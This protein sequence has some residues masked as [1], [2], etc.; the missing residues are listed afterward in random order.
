MGRSLRPCRSGVL[1]VILALWAAYLGAERLSF[2]TFSVEDGLPQSQ[3]TAL[4][5]DRSGYLWIGTPG[6]G[7]SRF[8]GRQFDNYRPQLGERRLEAR[9]AA[10][11]EARLVEVAG[12]DGQLV[13]DRAGDLWVGTDRGLS[14]LADGKLIGLPQGMASGV[15]PVLALA[16]DPAGG[17]RIGTDSGLAHFD[18]RSTWIFKE[19]DGLPSRYILSLLVDRRGV[20]WVGTARDV[21]RYRDVTFL[22]APDGSRLARRS[23]RA[24]LETDAGELW[25]GSDRRGVARFDGRDWTH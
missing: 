14:R 16:E 12:G 13:E 20:L 24:M 8:D 21:V 5:Q 15:S 2:R 6:G 7:V 22:P 11:A 19:D 10:A 4:A 18:G 3:V 23:V 25:F 9:V 17:L 1:T